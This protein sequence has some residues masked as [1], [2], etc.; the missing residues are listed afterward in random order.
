MTNLVRTAAISLAPR[1]ISVNA[2]APA[3]VRTNIAGGMLAHT[4]PET[5]PVLDEIAR[6]TPLGRLA[7]PTEFAGIAVFLA[8]TAS[9]YMTGTTVAVD[10][11]WLAW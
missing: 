2:I 6:R 10:G 3:F 4:T 1:R 7:E 5:Q 11:G 8:S 9:T